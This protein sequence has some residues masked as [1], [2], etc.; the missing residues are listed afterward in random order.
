MRPNIIP[1]SPKPKCCYKHRQ[2]P[3]NQTRVIHRRRVDWQSEREAENDDEYHNVQA[4]EPIN[5]ESSKSFHPQPA[6][7]N[8]GP[9]AQQ[10]GKY[11]CEIREC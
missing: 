11:R 4:S 3:C 9:F 5:N 1:F 10:V 8:V 2:P 7:G 6:R